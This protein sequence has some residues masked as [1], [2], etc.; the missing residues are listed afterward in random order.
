MRVCDSSRPEESVT[1]PVKPLRSTCA[2]QIAVRKKT[3]LNTINARRLRRSKHLRTNC[4]L[5]FNLRC[6]QPPTGEIGWSSEYKDGACRGYFHCG[7][8]CRSL[9]CIG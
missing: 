2:K 8:P 5:L 9:R 1:V 3:T 6:I 7:S 4:R